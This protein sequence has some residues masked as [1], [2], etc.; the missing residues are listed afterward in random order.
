MASKG[1]ERVRRRGIVGGKRKESWWERWCL[2]SDS[3]F[4]PLFW[5]NE[6]QQE[7]HYNFFPLHLPCSVDLVSQEFSV[8]ELGGEDKEEK[9][10]I[11]RRRHGSFGPEKGVH[12]ADGAPEFITKQR[13]VGWERKTQANHFHNHLGCRVKLIQLTSIEFPFLSK[14]WASNHTKRSW[15]RRWKRGAIIKIHWMCNSWGTNGSFLSS[16]YYKITLKSKELCLTAV[17]IPEIIMS[18]FTAE[19]EQSEGWGKYKLEPQCRS[20]QRSWNTF[21]W[22]SG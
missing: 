19:G 13:S 2:F 11:W 9:L 12:G 1:Q 3:I 7:A 16:R 20:Q 5:E 14:V 22:T 18:V 8:Q 6:L 10:I 21:Y 15:I 17:P 4:I